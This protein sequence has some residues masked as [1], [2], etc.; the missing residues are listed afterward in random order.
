MKPATKIAQ[1]NA[2]VSHILKSR[3]HINWDAK[4]RQ[5]A[6]KRCLFQT[7]LLLQPS[8]TF[9]ATLE[10]CAAKAAQPPPRQRPEI[11]SSNGADAI[12]D[13]IALVI[14]GRWAA[15][16]R[17]YRPIPIARCGRQSGMM[18]TVLVPHVGKRIRGT[19]SHTIAPTTS[20]QSNEKP[21][22]SH[23]GRRQAEASNFRT[24]K[25]K[26]GYATSRP[27]L[28][29]AFLVLRLRSGCWAYQ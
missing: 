27:E 26:P 19:L 23:R 3:L 1:M 13:G 25:H 22:P 9:F 28:R 20:T 4:Q 16:M 5:V 12:N 29:S 2:R 10:S 8:V 21:R 11:I 7:G 17:T 24:A 15:S 14:T 18:F 6:V